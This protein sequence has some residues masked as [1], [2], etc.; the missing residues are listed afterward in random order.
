MAPLLLNK[1]LVRS[2][3]PGVPERAGRIVEVEAYRGAADPASHA[4]RGRTARN[5]VMFGPPGHLY[6]YFTY[7][8]HFCANV[9]CMPEGTAEAVL[10][11]ALAPLRGIDEMRAGRGTVADRQ[12]TNGPAKLCQA[13]AITRAEDGADVVSGHGAVRI[14]D[15]G[16]PPPAAPGVSGRVGVSV[17]ADRPWRWWVPDDPNVSRGRFLLPGVGPPGGGGRPRRPD[18]RR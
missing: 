15:D 2:G 13:L 7:G 8:M 12:L 3:A 5:A 14:V 6:V 11:R 17:A 9:V 18:R 10:V 4:Y 1:V 16:V